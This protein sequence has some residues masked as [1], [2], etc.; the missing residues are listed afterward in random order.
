MRARVRECYTKNT[1]FCAVFFFF[2]DAYLPDFTNVPFSLHP[3][4]SR[5]A[6]RLDAIMLSTKCES[7]LPRFWRVFVTCLRFK[8]TIT[9][10]L[11]LICLA[12]L[13]GRPRAAFATSFS[14]LVKSR[15]YYL[16][17]ISLELGLRVGLPRT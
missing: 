17:L 15:A 8:T 14:P 5:A 10:Q 6:T 16:A 11:L 12:R 3:A 9:T 2:N 4:E 7:F 1:I 13:A